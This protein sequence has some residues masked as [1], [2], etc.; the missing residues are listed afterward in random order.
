MDEPLYVVP[1][2]ARRWLTVVNHDLL[3]S[4]SR[5]VSIR[6]V[7]PRSAYAEFQ[8]DRALQGK[9]KGTSAARERIHSWEERRLREALELTDAELLGRAPDNA[10]IA[11][12]E[13]SA[14]R[15]TMGRRFCKLGVRL[16]DGSRQRWI[17]SS[18]Y[19]PVEEV[20]PV[21]RRLLGERLA[22]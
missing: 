3:I 20:E 18:R 1:N 21:L 10:I 11:L 16:E 19:A 15:L 13:I 12:A 5:L 2:T 7:S 4:E 8:V 6:S 22:R 17:W 9:V 14:A